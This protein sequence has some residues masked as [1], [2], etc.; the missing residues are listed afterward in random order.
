MAD[1]KYDFLNPQKPLSAFENTG[2]G[3]YT[4]FA[5]AT[6]GLSPFS[7]D[8]TP[9]F[10]DVAG[11]KSPFA[12]FL[13]K[14]MGFSSETPLQS[15]DAQN[16]AQ[17]GKSDSSTLMSLHESLMGLLGSRGNPEDAGG[18]W[19][20]SATGQKYHV[21][22]LSPTDAQGRSQHKETLP[23]G[24]D[25]NAPS[26]VGWKGPHSWEEG[27]DY[28]N[29]MRLNVEDAAAGTLPQIKE[30]QAETA[31]KTGE[32]KAKMGALKDTKY[33]PTAESQQI[34]AGGRASLDSN[35]SHATDLFNDAQ[36]LDKSRMSTQNAGQFS[37]MADYQNALASHSLR[38]AASSYSQDGFSAMEKAAQQSAALP[39]AGTLRSIQGGA[40][41]S[42]YSSPTGGKIKPLKDKLFPS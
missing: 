32:L 2:L 35:L 36:A 33:D 4:K 15:Q 9:L 16:T 34:L 13:G 5:T 6:A 42:A 27:S 24:V 37:T 26:S 31:R 21:A 38:R 30:R 25:P 12:D 23:F 39:G 22:S 28:T 10:S 11:G 18:K 7:E 1:D 17:S 19:K 14:P 3:D 29:A 20:T 40:Y 8:Y 41:G